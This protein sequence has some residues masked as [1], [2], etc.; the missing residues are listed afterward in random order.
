M[1]RKFKLVITSSLLCG[2][3]ALS[4]TSFAQT[5]AAPT[6]GNSADNTAMN[7]RDRS[8]D[9]IKP[10]DQPN[11]KVDIALAASVRNAIV[12]DKSLSTSAHNVKLIAASGHVTLRGPVMG[13]D[14]KT[15]VGQI[16]ASVQGVSDVDNQLDVKTN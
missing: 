12:S 13:P 6:T 5:T 9:T 1:D 15:K 3:L 10:T 4:G 2:S 14:E 7:T 8:T 16:V 11:N